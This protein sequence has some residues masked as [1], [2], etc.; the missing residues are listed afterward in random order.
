MS[1]TVSKPIPTAIPLPGEWLGRRVLIR[2]YA[3]A[4]AAAVGEAVA[5]SRDELRPWM[6]WVDSH[7]TIEGTIDFCARSQAEWLLR[8]NLNLAIFERESGRYL[9][10]T[11]FHRLDWTARTFEIGYWLRT[12]AVGH[13]Y[14]TESVRVLTRGA[15]EDMAANRVRIQCDARNVRSRHVAERCGYVLE[16]TL[17][18]DE[19]T[20]AGQLR[21][22]LMFSL[23][24]EEFEAL[25]P[26]W[27]EAFP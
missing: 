8:T 4:D 11:G 10:G 25:L 21:D 24:R 5:E 13:G 23:L 2:P 15:Y 7:R 6:P 27:R 14:M 12:S 26:T 16:G 17:R 9:G 19:L 18:R 3:V 22:T 20:T 1:A